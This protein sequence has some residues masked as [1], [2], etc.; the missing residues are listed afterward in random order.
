M[1]LRLTK[2]PYHSDEYKDEDIKVAIVTCAFDNPEIIH[3][4]KERGKAIKN[5]DWEELDRINNKMTDML[6]SC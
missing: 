3:G 5:E 2:L 6:H 1:E 4:L